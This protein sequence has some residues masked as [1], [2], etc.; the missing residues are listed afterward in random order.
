[1]RDRTSTTT[2]LDNSGLSFKLNS[3]LPSCRKPTHASPPTL[4]QVPPLAPHP[5]TTSSVLVPKGS[6]RN[7]LPMWL[8]RLS[9]LSSLRLQLNRVLSSS[10]SLMP[11]TQPRLAD[12]FLM[13]AN[14]PVSRG[15]M[16][17]N[18]KE[19]HDVMRRNITATAPST[20]TQAPPQS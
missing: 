15:Q 18:F 19:T 14:P 7:H 1:M 16:E 3:G 6:G 2:A 20:F 9:I 13:T 17:P 10:M 5:L 4:C 8:C 12:S 11:T